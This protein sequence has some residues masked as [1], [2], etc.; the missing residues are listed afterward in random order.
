MKQRNYSI[1]LVKFY[2]AL[3]IAVWHTPFGASFPTFDAA[4]V[5]TLFFV[6]SGYFLVCSSDS[7]K[8]ADPW[9]Y[10]M[11]RVRKIYPYY[12]VAFVIIFLYARRDSGIRTIVLEFWRYVPEMLM[13]QSVGVFPEG[14]NYP[15]WQLSTLVVVSHI[16][17]TM[18]RWNRQVMLNAVCPVVSVCA[19]HYYIQTAEEALLP[20]SPFVYA[21]L[22]RA[23]AGLCLGMFLHDPIRM[24][25]KRM[26]ESKCRSMPWLVSA[27]SIFLMLVFWTNRMTYGMILPFVGIMICMLYSKSIWARAFRHPVFGH[28]DKLSLSVYVNHAV[29]AWIFEFNPAIY[30]NIPLPEDILYLAVLIPYCIILTALVD[31]LLRVAGRMMHRGAEEKA[32]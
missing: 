10:T 24:V 32:V 29:I 7:G 18:L 8:Y 13:V 25:L 2:F 17:F 3:V 16:L 26:E 19:F 15:L 30:E 28:L 31:Y 22:I 20:A 11:N 14:Q 23:A 1:D 4:Y 6:L 21:P 12:F 9:Q 27:A 5:V